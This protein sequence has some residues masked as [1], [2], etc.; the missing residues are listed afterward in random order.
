MKNFN[1]IDSVYVKK[2]KTVRLKLSKDYIADPSDDESPKVENPDEIYSILKSLYTQ[3]DDDQEHILM[4][5]LNVV[6]EVIGFKIISSGTQTSGPADAK[7]IFR[8][9]LLL[10][11]TK[12]ILAHNHPG[13]SLKP[14]KADIS[15]TEKVIGA[16][17]SI[18]IPVVDHIIFTYNGY[19]S[20]RAERVCVFD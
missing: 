14:S 4:I 6:N 19:L 13:G 2:L 11:A 9:A 5:V 1:K 15:F 16:G 12:I 20:M 8:S 17:K 18:D 7:I 3:L 10:G